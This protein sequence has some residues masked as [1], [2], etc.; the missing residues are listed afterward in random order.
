M[1]T[2]RETPVL[3]V[4][5]VDDLLGVIPVLLR[6][7]PEESLVVVA[8][9]GGSVA[10]TARVDLDEV[11]SLERLALSLRPVWQRYPD[12]DLLAVAYSARPE[13]GWRV[14]DHL[15]AAAPPGAVVLDAVA[16]GTCWY[17]E[18]GDAG[19][20][21]DPTCT[22]HAAVAAFSGVLVRASRDELA[23][24]VEPA[25]RL[26]EVGV[27]LEALDATDDAG[28]GL[29][30]RRLLTDA[31]HGRPAELTLRER[32]T[33]MLA[34]ADPQFFGLCLT[35]TNRR[36]AA[37]LLELWIQVVRGS[38]PELAGPAFVLTG[39]AA[40]VTGDGALQVICQERAAHVD[41]DH[42]WVHFLDRVNREVVPPE[43]WDDI[44]AWCLPDLLAG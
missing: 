24:A 19:A 42:P 5:S 20:P 9:D 6:F 22:R 1:R 40:W 3:R 37:S 32:L 17:A 14:L 30:A 28:V 43:A 29:A 26:D 12:A 25:F 2:F 13:L 16:D 7:H 34:A 11:A 4:R 8:V 39:I 10:V 33:L 18:P 36:N 15:Q 31:L 23:S 35:V 44:R 27:E 38:L 21:Y 41:P